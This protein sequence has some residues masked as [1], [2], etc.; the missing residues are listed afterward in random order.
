MPEG[1]AT[2]GRV[3]TIE[4]IAGAIRFLEGSAGDTVAAALERLFA[5][6]V[7]HTAATGRNIGA[8]PP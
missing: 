7:A 6:A 5:V 8:I 4:A 1:A 3:S 2:P